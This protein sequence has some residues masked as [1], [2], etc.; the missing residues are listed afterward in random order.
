MNTDFLKKWSRVC[1]RHTHST[2]WIKP[3]SS[4]WLQEFRKLPT[5]S[6]CFLFHLKIMNILY[7][8]RLKAAQQ[9][10][11]YKDLLLSFP[12][13]MML[14]SLNFQKKKK[15]KESL[16]IGS[17]TS[18]TAKWLLENPRLI[19]VWL[20]FSAIMIFTVILFSP[21]VSAL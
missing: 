9:I 2:Y 16:D 10:Q 6:F 3:N 1:L 15:K 18:K 8:T 19:L 4:V 12:H 13:Y 20:V 14:M 7:C 21:N 17:R 5:S 11:S